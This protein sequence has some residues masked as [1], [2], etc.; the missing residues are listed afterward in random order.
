MHV[1]G[2]LDLLGGRA[3]HARGGAR[4]RY[5]P[6]TAIA[7]TTIA[8]GD[9]L[10][11]AH[12]YTDRCGV[13]ELYVADLDAI[14][15][16][17][18]H[19]AILTALATLDVPVWLDAGSETLDDARRAIALGASRAVVGME[20]LRGWDA[21]D[22]ICQALGAARTAFSLDLR[23]GHPVVA[24]TSG[25]RAGQAPEVIGARAADAGVGSLILLDLA[26][27]GSG[28]GVDCA[29]VSRVRH[30][31]PDVLLVAGGGIRGQ[32]DIARLSDA[33]C[34]AALVATALLD[35]RLTAAHVSPVRRAR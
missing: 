24:A 33:G 35:G 6:V 25:I 19:D 2:V 5:A 30:A 31:A 29:L 27:V 14:G 12:A 28:R 3:V 7:G 32:E 11:L 21:L 22:E 13:R 16:G 4:D 1:I 10:A 17:A 18:P 23:D 9:A 15:G 20:T 34:D 26:R 8:A